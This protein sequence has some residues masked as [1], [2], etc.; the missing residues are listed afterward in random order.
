MDDSSVHLPWSQGGGMSVFSPVPERRSSLK[1]RL[2]KSSAPSLRSKGN[3]GPHLPLSH[4]IPTV[5]PTVRSRGK[6]SSPL[7]R[8]DSHIRKVLSRTVVPAVLPPDLS[9]APKISHP[10]IQL[11][12]RLLSPVFV[13]GATVE[14]DVHLVVD[15]G[16]G[17]KKRKHGQSISIGRIYVTVVGIERCRG[18]QEIF[19]VLMTDLVHDHH[20]L[21]SHLFTE[22]RPEKVWVLAP[23][24]TVIPFCVDLPINM[25]PPP[26]ESRKAGISYLASVTVE[27]I[28]AGRSHLVRHSEEIAV[29]SVHDR[30]SVYQ[31]MAV[32]PMTSFLA[33][34]ALVNL[35]EPLL[36]TDEMRVSHR[37]GAQHIILSAGI[38]RQ[39]WIS[40]YPIF[41]DIQINSPKGKTVRNIELQL[42]K[43]T[44]YHSQP[45]PATRMGLVESLRLPDHIQREVIA[46]KE[47]S[48]GLR[49]ILPI[50]LDYRTYEMDL[51]SGL[52][53]ISMGM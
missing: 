20:P 24:S 43:T 49:G 5:G 40:G 38:H 41:V 1:T 45:A 18:R 48:T 31:S 13:G 33:E 21:P 34:K 15:G 44:T 14:G 10:R 17:T 23:S 27:A 9:T 28:I 52:V 11:D 29:L 3:K 37:L 30:K 26:Y 4:D 32:L 42:E 19:R 53:S 47:V 51:P 39:T 46:R 50:T 8:P 22:K 16:S 2:K 35:S 36:V 25:G 7:R 12:L 6:S